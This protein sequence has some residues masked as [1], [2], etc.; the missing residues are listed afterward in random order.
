MTFLPLD[1]RKRVFPIKKLLRNISVPMYQREFFFSFWLLLMN[2]TW[3]FGDSAGM[4]A[5]QTAFESTQPPGSFLL[6][7]FR[8]P[9]Q[10]Q[11]SRRTPAQGAS[12]L[13]QLFLMATCLKLRTIALPFATLA[14]LASHA[15]LGAAA[16]CIVKLDD[17]LQFSV[18]KDWKNVPDLYR[19]FLRSRG[20]ASCLTDDEYVQKVAFLLYEKRDSNEVNFQRWAVALEEFATSG[21]VGESPDVEQL[22]SWVR[23]FLFAVV[24][25]ACPYVSQMDDDC[26]VSSLSLFDRTECFRKEASSG[27][28]TCGKLDLEFSEPISE[29]DERKLQKCSKAVHQQVQDWNALEGERLSHLLEVFQA[30]WK[31]LE[32][33]YRVANQLP[34]WLGM[35]DVTKEPNSTE[36]ALGSPQVEGKRQTVTFIA[37]KRCLPG[38]ELRACILGTLMWKSQEQCSLFHVFYTFAFDLIFTL[39][40]G[41]AQL[42]PCSSIASKMSM[43]F[44]V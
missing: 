2:C 32:E 36:V 15:V 34:G 13:S 1:C 9:V 21:E 17:S 5:S 33:D 20:G 3:S 39:L 7:R 41:A 26:Y 38:F 30:E 24:D 27:G 12:P 28:V 18:S 42:V 16:D 40:F 37:R 10:Q 22:I 23:S 11:K 35:V 19:R 14:L 4:A 25:S 29:A 31:H 44:R 8:M 43:D 6:N